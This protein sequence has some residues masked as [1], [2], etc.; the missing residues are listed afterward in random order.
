MSPAL[1]SKAHLQFSRDEVSTVVA[2][3][4]F[5]MGIDKPDVRRV[6]HLG[7][8]QSLESY[9]QEVGR[10]G[11]D[12]LAA[13]CLVLYAQ[14]DFTW[15]H[16]TNAQSVRTHMVFI[17]LFCVSRS[18]ARARSLSLPLALSCS[19]LLSLAL[20]CSLFLALFLRPS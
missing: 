18:S 15:S 11:R 9:Y 19:L 12:G 3:V 4:A 6:V 5:G 17:A 14:K 10:A 16:G 2:T 20:S 13:R 8:P 1:R 7:A